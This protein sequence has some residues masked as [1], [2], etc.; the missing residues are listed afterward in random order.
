M[1]EQGVGWFP[2]G[3]IAAELC[4]W[5]CGGVIDYVNHQEVHLPGC[6]LWVEPVV[7]I[8]QTKYS[9]IWKLGWADEGLTNDKRIPRT[10]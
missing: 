7:R 4:P 2:E 6:P 1:A 9:G 10:K 3:G 8:H 5:L